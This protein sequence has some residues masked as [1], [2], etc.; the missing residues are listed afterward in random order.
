M[1]R[2]F[3]SKSKPNNA[4]CIF[5]FLEVK[6]RSRIRRCPSTIASSVNP[7]RNR[8]RV[9]TYDGIYRP[10]DDDDDDD[11]NDGSR[12][13]KLRGG[14]LRSPFL[15]LRSFPLASLRSPPRSPPWA[16]G[17]VSY[18]VPLHSTAP[19]SA[20]SWTPTFHLHR[21]APMRHRDSCARR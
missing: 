5:P 19:H 18:L 10:R 1:S 12:W 16:S 21:A 20:G 17:R 15:S 9:R 3:P 11:G 6:W 14:V 13:L 2:S 7:K 8:R 4:I